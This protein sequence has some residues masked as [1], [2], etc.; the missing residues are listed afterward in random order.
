M[1][2][3]IVGRFVGVLKIVLL[4]IFVLNSGRGLFEWIVLVFYSVLCCMKLSFV[5]IFVLVS[6]VMIVGFI[7]VCC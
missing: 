6:C 1:F 7:F 3:V 4:F 2:N 5:N